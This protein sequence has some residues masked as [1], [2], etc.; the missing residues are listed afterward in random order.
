MLPDFFKIYFL[1]PI[2]YFKLFIFYFNFFSLFNPFMWL[3]AIDLDDFL[4]IIPLTILIKK[5]IFQL[6][7]INGLIF[8][9][10]IKKIK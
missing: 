9:T 5:Y 1:Y 4:G 8:K 6:F 7:I 2:L 10:Q 3:L